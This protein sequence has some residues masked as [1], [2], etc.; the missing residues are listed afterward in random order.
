MLRSSRR[1]LSTT[2]TAWHA[3]EARVAAR[4]VGVLGVCE[5]R[6]GTFMRGPAQAPALIRKYFHEPAVN[7]CSELGF[8]V[9]PRIVDFGDVTPTG[10][11][12]V[13]IAA[14]VSGKV[15]EIMRTPSMTPF[16]LGGDHSVSFALISAVRQHVGRPLT[17]VHFDAHPDIYP[18]YEGDLNSHACPFAR[19]LEVPGLCAQ[20]IS[21]GV[22]CISGAQIPLLV[23][24]GVELI[25]AKDFPTKGHDILPVLKKH[26]RSDDTPVYLSFDLDCLD[27]AAAPGV[28]H[29]EAG[30]LTA[31]QAIDAIHCVPGRLVGADLVE[32]NPARDTPDFLTASVAAKIMKEIAG[33]LLLSQTGLT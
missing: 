6:N 15:A 10:R 11:E 31:R 19:V 20:L 25:E 2:V 33:K 5:D 16:F 18:H 27:P 30:G 21:V 24:H 23:R 32:Y 12:H 26:I 22:R 8:D 28:S 29:R 9:A 13:H 7:T 17:V 1:T 3:T 14:A 4:S